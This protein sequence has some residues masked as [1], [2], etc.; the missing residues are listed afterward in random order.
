MKLPRAS[1]ATTLFVI[2]VLAVDLGV[3]RDLLEHDR[4][5]LSDY[6]LG[7]LPMATALVFGLYRLARLRALAGAFTVGFVAVGLA[8]LGGY[9][10]AVQFVPALN[11][12]MGRLCQAMD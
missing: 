6:G 1:M 11:G 7:F 8:A 9:L 4:G 3:T 12:T 5:N 2:L 10:A